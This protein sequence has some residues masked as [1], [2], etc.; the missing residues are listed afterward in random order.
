LRLEEARSW[1]CG[2]SIWE[3][4]Q[5]LDY[6]F[7]LLWKI[8]CVLLFMSSVNVYSYLYSSCIKY[9][10]NGLWSKW[11]FYFRVNMFYYVNMPLSA[12]SPCKIQQ[13]EIS[14]HCNLGA[15]LI[16]WFICTGFSNFIV[17]LIFG[18]CSPC[19]GFLLLVCRF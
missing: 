17:L 14:L 13:S 6:F 5:G 1:G 12:S 4:G 10:C 9:N 8:A 16:L 18:V 15:T 11:E 3:I 7:D 19:F 2:I